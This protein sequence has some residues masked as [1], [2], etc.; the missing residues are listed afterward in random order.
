[1]GRSIPPRSDRRGRSCRLTR[2]TRICL[3]GKWNIRAG[4]EERE[5]VRQWRGGGC[6]DGCCAG[7]GGVF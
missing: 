5:G 7:W 6:L 1:M 2:G 3:D 4:G